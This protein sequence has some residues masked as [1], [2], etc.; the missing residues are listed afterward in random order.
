MYNYN[1]V[2][3]SLALIS[4]PAQ[5]FLNDLHIDIAP[6]C[7]WPCVVVKRLKPKAL[8]VK[9]MMTNCIHVEKKAWAG[10]RA[11]DIEFHLRYVGSWH[12]QVIQLQCFHSDI[13][14]T[15]GN[16]VTLSE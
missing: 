16:D 14:I 13:Y 15:Y 9:I 5:L 2:N 11:R 4:F 12:A 8:Q 3:I 10:T 1:T 7:L 6:T